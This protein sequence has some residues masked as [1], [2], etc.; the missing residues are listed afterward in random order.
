MLKAR[1][2]RVLIGSG[3]AALLVFL[4]PA[5][6]LHAQ[7]AEPD[8][9]TPR[10]AMATFLGA[11]EREDWPRA[12]AVL[13]VRPSAA[14]AKKDQ[15]IVLS[16]QL[17]F[18][19]S[20]SLGFQLDEVSD[21]PEGK[22]EDGALSE[23]VGAVRVDGRWVPIVL[24]RTGTPPARWIV[25]S[26]TLTS[27]PELYRERGPSPL[28][29]YVPPSLRTETLGIAR[30][31]WLGL[32]LGALLA[33][34]V[35]QLLVYL[36]TKASLHLAA[37]T[38]TPWDDRVIRALKAPA[39]LFVSIFLFVPIAHAMSLPS[40]ARLVVIR[41]AGTLALIAIAWT[42]LRVVGLISDFVEQR[43]ITAAAS[44]GD[45]GVR[46]RGIRTKVRVLRRVI[47]VLLA[48]CAGAVVLMQFEV[49]RSVGVSLLASAGLAG[50]VLGF[51]AQRTL[52]SLVG[53]VQ[54]SITQPI[55][56]GDDV[57]V[58][59]EFGTIEEITLTYVVVKLWDERRLIVPMSRF[60]EQPFQNWTKE[61]P[62]LHGTVM[63]YADFALPVDAVRQELDRLLTDHPLWDGRTKAVHVTDVKERTI[64]IRILVSAANGGALF[65]LRAEMRERLVA[66]LVR[67][68]SGRYLPLTRVDDAGPDLADSERASKLPPARAPE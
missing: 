7:A 57:I 21:S 31:Q 26:A 20:R 17:D 58:E 43:A 39:R 48:V 6:T 52:G 64:E 65:N 47:S 51:A 37:R 49:V 35:A 42:L 9:S 59:N 68:E 53:G 45:A 33:T 46:G 60:L 44:V 19:L 27:V 38:Q 24:T 23:Q 14:E 28:E 41:V 18:V 32:P 66:W 22:P 34:V 16:R 10:R 3:L 61:S 30:W 5:S 2:A 13:G 62:Q 8:L 25:S 36:G 4:M 40:S 15:A 1:L 67:L 63:L 12:I 50:V 29:P 56:I 11:V 55:R 54:L